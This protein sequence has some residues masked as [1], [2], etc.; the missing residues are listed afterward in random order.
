MN[1]KDL[2]DLKDRIK[3]RA[4]TIKSGMFIQEFVRDE[5]LERIKG[6]NR[7]F[8]SIS[9]V[10]GFSELWLKAVPS[11]KIVSDLSLIHI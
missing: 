4:R 11:A 7:E 5:I 1:Q 8:K 9:I 3:K 10:T 2:F 6:I